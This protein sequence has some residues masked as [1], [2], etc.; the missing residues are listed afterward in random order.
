[1]GLDIHAAQVDIEI[2]LP[3][4]IKPTDKTGVVAAVVALLTQDE[5]IGLLLRQAA[6]GRRRMESFQ[7][8]AQQ[9]GPVER[10]GKEAF[11]V[12]HLARLDGKGAFL[13][14]VDAQRCQLLTDVIGDELLF[15][16]VLVAPRLGQVAVDERLR[17]RQGNR[18]PTVPPASR[19]SGV[20]PIQ[21]P[22]SGR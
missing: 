11:K 21:V 16:P 10:E 18:L 9:V 3:G 20:L 1:M 15:P 4:R 5:T 7:Q 19:I 2:G 22:I 6:D 13:I 17:T 8:V 12:R 14:R